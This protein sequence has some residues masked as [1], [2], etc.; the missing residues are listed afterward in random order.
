MLAALHPQ[1]QLSNLT[2]RDTD[3]ERDSTNHDFQERTGRM[4]R[5]ALSISTVYKSITAF[6]S[7]D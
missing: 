4:V 1:V 2:E 5:C 3:L 6:P 7:H